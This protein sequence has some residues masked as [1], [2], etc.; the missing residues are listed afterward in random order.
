MVISTIMREG[1]DVSPYF[2]RV[3]TNEGD[4]H[5]LV[6]TQLQ[7]PLR[8]ETRP[9]ALPFEFTK[10]LCD[11]SGRDTQPDLTDPGTVLIARVVI[12]CA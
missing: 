7:S 1:F 3:L 6:A 2:Y 10:T 11:G 5:N 4:F 12:K 8:K 9:V